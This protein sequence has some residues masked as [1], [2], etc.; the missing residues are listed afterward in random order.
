MRQDPDF[1]DPITAHTRS[2]FPLLQTGMSVAEALEKIRREGASERIIYF[3][4]VDAESKLAGVLPTRRL[5]TAA[6]ETSVAEIMVPRVIALPASATVL[7]ACEFF[8]LYKFFA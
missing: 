6:V 2:E 5:L 4:V 7:D 3:Y 8:V 1:S